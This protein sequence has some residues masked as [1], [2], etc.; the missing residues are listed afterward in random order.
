MCRMWIMKRKIRR[1][2]RDCFYLRHS[3]EAFRKAVAERNGAAPKAVLREK[4]V[5]SCEETII[6]RRAEVSLVNSSG[7]SYN[8]IESLFT[9]FNMS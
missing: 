4:G 3:P 7:I 9:Y 1:K 2:I 5:K 6:L 8:R